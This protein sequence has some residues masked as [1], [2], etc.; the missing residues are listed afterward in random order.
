MLDLIPTR[1]VKTPIYVPPAIEL[2]D[3]NVF[4][5]GFDFPGTAALANLEHAEAVREDFLVTHILGVTDAPKGT[6][7]LQIYHQHGQEQ[8]QL[9][10]TPRKLEIAAGSAQRPLLLPSPYLLAAG[11]TVTVAI[12]NTGQ[13][14][15]GAYVAAYIQVALWGIHP[16]K[17]SSV[18]H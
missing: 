12:A 17:V 3:G 7:F 13:S 18:G 11:D 5:L 6:F 14:L 9:F 8:R 4:T 10:D 16:T 15:A 1:G 2:P